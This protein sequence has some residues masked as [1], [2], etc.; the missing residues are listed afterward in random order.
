MQR[1]ELILEG[2]ACANCADKIER[3][4]QKIMGISSAK[5]DF[6][7]QKLTIEINDG[8]ILNDIINEV[9]TIT[10]QI[11]PDVKVNINEGHKPRPAKPD[12]SGISSELIKIIIGG[13]IFA[14]AVLFEFSSRTELILYLTSYVIAGY[15]VLLR[16]AKSIAKGHVF[17]EYFLM[18]IASI[19]AFMV[20]EYPEGV[21][22]MLFYSVGELFQDMAVA[23]SRKSIG[24]LMDIMPDYANLKVGNDFERVSPSSV[25]TGDI[26]LIKPG[27]K[28]PLDAEVIEG[29]SLVDTSALTGESLPREV[30]PGSEILS[31]FIN[32][33]S[34]LTARVT[35]LYGESTAYKILD[36]VENAAGRKAPTE[37]FISKFARY[38]TPFVV[39]SALALALIPPLF[40]DGSSFSVWA[41]R[42]LI[43]LV[44]SCPCALV[45]SI[46]LSFFGGIGGASRQGILVKGSN[47]L[48]ALNHVDTVV[49]DKTGT[50]T[51]GIF[52]VSK[53][54]PYNDFT[55]EELIKYAAY[56]EN[57]A[58][59][60]VAASI[61]NAYHGTID[62]D[63]IEKYMEIEG[64]GV[65]ALIDGNEVLLGN[66]K[67]MGNK[68]IN[69]V[70]DGTG[71]ASVFVS[72]NGVFAGSIVISD[73]VKEDAAKAI[74][75]LK[76]AGVKKTVML[77][78]DI[79][80]VGE[81]TAHALGIDEV[82]TDLLPADKVNKLEELENKKA[83]KGNLIYVGDGI[84]DAPVLARADIGIA[85]GG[86][87]SD[88]AIEAADVVIM[89]DEPSKIAVAIKLA[90]KT[91]SIVMQNIVFALGV[92]AAVLLLGGAGHA[93]MWGA[94]FADI[95]VAL[96]TIFNA[97]RVMQTKNI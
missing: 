93:S 79:K 58:S 76:E 44:V 59:H 47:Y 92:K 75:D 24:A 32:K 86:L 19:G 56:A 85:M 80:S 21:A 66:A 97:M 78:G 18:S 42:A 72:V 13:V 36:L 87:G 94:V 25:K 22:V 57:Y 27:E 88:A 60:P 43:F 28:V 37:N 31:G 17:S 64:H 29:E 15:E 65:S 53:I 41:Y 35:K 50:L 82:Y 9:K 63:K 68:N 55:A 12:V 5:V 38:Y 91:R 51:K 11:E 33:N 74:S 67:L 71:G 4:T 20:G 3:Q 8:K 6:V 83:S 61:L 52:K 89:N 62:K 14:I 30:E 73:Q 7:S 81:E 23:R 2:L 84:N 45:I 26:I 40:I 48:E 34:V 39:L 77:T 49:F 70:S 10:R 46:P 90:K 1:T 95:G 96:I 54:N 69:F 16:S